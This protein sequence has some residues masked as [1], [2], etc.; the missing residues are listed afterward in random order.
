M[1]T[2]RRSVRPEDTSS[3]VFNRMADVYGARPA[4]PEALVD[5]LA[6]CVG[7]GGRRV[8]DIGAG[9][10][11]LALPLAARGFEVTAVEPASEMLG[12][13]REAAIAR[14][15]SITTVHAAAEALPLADASADLAVIADALH[16]IEAQR[17]A[18]E[19]ERVLAKGS[20]LAIVTCALGD[21]PFMQSVVRVMEEAAPR[22][23]RSVTALMTQ[24]AARSGVTPCATHTFDDATA[25]D[26]ATLEQI[27][28][29]ISFI[30]PAMNQ[31]R[32]DAFRA[33]IHA[34]PGPRVWARSFTLRVYRRAR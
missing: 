11:H 19:L 12:R 9:V 1:G 23:P 5:A 8:V 26:A 31:A 32:F 7:P 6:E 22:R 17:A 29:S 21:T 13:L 33:R 18:A 10:G 27:L 15:V 28:R 2:G 24:L 34:L 3:W 20:A 14:G 25:V 30:G 16:F 4:Y